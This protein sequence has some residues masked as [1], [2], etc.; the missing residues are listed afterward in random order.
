MTANSVM[1]DRVAVTIAI[2][3]DCLGHIAVRYSLTSREDQMV[4]AALAAAGGALIHLGEAKAGDDLGEV[5]HRL[6][7]RERLRHHG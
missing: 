2:L 5:V 1:D 4:Q 7:E 3:T 6:I